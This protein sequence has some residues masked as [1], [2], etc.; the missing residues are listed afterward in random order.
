MNVLHLIRLK[1][2]DHD[3]IEI[4]DNDYHLV[5]SYGICATHDN[6]HCEGFWCYYS[7]GNLDNNV[8]YED[9]PQEHNKWLTIYWE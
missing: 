4:L 2:N 3:D 7:D 6:C 8:D 5:A 1:H 9:F